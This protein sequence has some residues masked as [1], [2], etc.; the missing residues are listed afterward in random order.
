MT[1]LEENRYSTHHKQRQKSQ[2]GR[3]APPCAALK[4]KRGPLPLGK[5]PRG[6]GGDL[7]SRARRPGT[8]SERRLDFRVR[9]GNGYD[10]ASRTAEIFKKSDRRKAENPEKDY[11]HASQSVMSCGIRPLTRRATFI[12]K[13]RKKPHG[14]LVSLGSAHR[15]AH[16]CDLSTSSSPTVLQGVAPARPDLGN[17]FTLRCFQR[18]SDPHMT[19]RRCRWRDSRYTRGA[20]VP[21]L[22]Y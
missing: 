13:K 17:G 19:T 14:L 11:S 20:S 2:K 5:G 16:T 15:C 7:L 4:T 8:I 6:S 22:S 21:V 10:P 3:R 1:L 18:F 9:N 12:E